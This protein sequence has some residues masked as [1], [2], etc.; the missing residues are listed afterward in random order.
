MKYMER[1]IKIKS[2]VEAQRSIITEAQEKIEK[3]QD[4]RKQPFRNQPQMG[5]T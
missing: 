1:N 5:K 3:L 4:K 2:P